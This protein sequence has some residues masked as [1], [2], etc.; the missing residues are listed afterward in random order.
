V[1]RRKAPAKIKSLV[2]VGAGVALAG[3][4]TGQIMRVTW[5]T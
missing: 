3:L 1:E 5:L 4:A 2:M